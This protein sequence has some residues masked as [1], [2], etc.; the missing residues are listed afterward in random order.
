M[1][2]RKAASTGLLAAGALLLF[3]CAPPKYTEY[4]SLRRDFKASVPWAWQVMTDEEG[5]HYT[6]TNFIGPFEPEFYLGAPSLSVRWYAYSYPHR[7]PDKTVEIYSSADDYIQRTLETVY[8]PAPHL[9][10]PPHDIELSAAGRK[11]RHLVVLSPVPVPE[12]TQWG[13]SIDVETKKLVNLR[14]HAYV[15]V[16]LKRG[17]YVLIY[18]ATR[19]GFRLYEPQ[20]N[21]LVN[22]FQ[23]LTDGPGGPAISGAAAKAAP[24]TVFPPK[25]RKRR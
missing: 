21:Q 7:L 6:N 19:D 9:R 25:S 15:V 1:N 3:A 12:G 20:F 13:T 10:Q 16:P 8:G 23:P 5:R 17:F 24:E 18:P 11:G 22:T 2:G 14:E 4:T